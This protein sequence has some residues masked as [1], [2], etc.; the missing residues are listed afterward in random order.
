[1]IMIKPMLA[2]KYNKSKFDSTSCVSE[3]LDGVRCLAVNE[4]GT[5]RLYT[6]TGKEIT[7]CDHISKE[8]TKECTWS[9]SLDGELYSE[10]LKFDEISGAVRSVNPTENSHK[11]E[12]RVFDVVDYKFIY[13]LRYD[14][15]FD[16][17]KDLKHTHIIPKRDVSTLKEVEDYFLSVL[18]RGGEGIIIRSLRS[19]YENKRSWGMMKLKK[20]STEEFLI[21]EINEGKGK[22]K[23][24]PIFTLKTK[25][26]T[27]FT[28]KMNGTYT[29]NRWLWKN[30]DLLTGKA[31]T[32]KFM[33]KT[34]NG[35]P[36]MPVGIEIRDYE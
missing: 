27:L 18:Q 35:V 33:E 31:I 8:L 16:L 12:F 17:V 22:D 30:R 29:R 3:K 6:R 4:N 13:G 26:G 5:F 15:L 20:E 21:E 19:N 28:C 2:H 25:D 9:Y 11:L 10:D 24:I 34:R 7:S 1:M 23:G 32:V 36:R 14:L